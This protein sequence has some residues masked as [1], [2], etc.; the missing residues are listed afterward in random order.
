MEN[1]Y[2]KERELL[3]KKDAGPYAYFEGERSAS[4]GTGGAAVW[5]VPRGS[6]H[7][8]SGPVDTYKA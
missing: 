5:P 6:S 1:I 8:K 7:L 4:V 3:P 2:L